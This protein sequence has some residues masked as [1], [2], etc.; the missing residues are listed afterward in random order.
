MARAPPVGSGD[1]RNHIEEGEDG[2]DYGNPIFGDSL[3]S[4]PPEYHWAAVVSTNHPHLRV[5]NASILATVAIGLV[6]IGAVAFDSGQAPI[7]ETVGTVL[8]LALVAALPLIY[9]IVKLRRAPSRSSLA[10]AVAYPVVVLGLV[11]FALKSEFDSGSE[12]SMNV[13]YSLV[14]FWFSIGWT[15]FLFAYLPAVARLLLV[16]WRAYRSSYSGFAPIAVWGA[17]LVVVLGTCAVSTR[18]VFEDGPAYRV[19]VVDNAL[20]RMNECI[21]RYA[22][23]ESDGPFP[24]S[25]EQIR[26]VPYRHFVRS[27]NPQPDDCREEIE[28]GA[29]YPFV[30]EYGSRTGDAA[31]GR[32]H[33]FT[34]RFTER[35]RPGGRPRVTWIDESGLRHHGVLGADGKVDSV[36]LA[37]T[38]PLQTM[39]VLEHSI[40]Q[41][42]A[43]HGKYPKELVPR[44]T[45]RPDVLAVDGSECSTAQTLPDGFCVEI[46]ERAIV[47]RRET[48]PAGQEGYTLTMAPRTFYDN[49]RQQ[50]IPSRT[51]FRDVAG[52]WHSFG[53]LRPAGPADPAPA[54]DEMAMARRD[55][56]RQL[57]RRP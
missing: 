42:A 26:T 10:L 47:Y 4:A 6:V 25:L 17:G 12:G 11:L 2:R 27:A 36:R 49:E 39:L 54:A 52:R 56:G 8:P 55:L 48:G 24:D 40:D 18:A 35:T 3:T 53:G 15:L 57:R 44:S 41:Y 16:S 14:F 31:A 22:G 45:D 20:D 21:W 28:R 5:R 50:P 32:P 34:L 37:S 46:W 19:D 23:P 13:T 30:V 33:F 7:G 38:T 9:L 51:H 1:D 29:K 43:S